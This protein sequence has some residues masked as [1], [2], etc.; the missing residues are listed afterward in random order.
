M[1]KPINN[2]KNQEAEREFIPLPPDGYVCK[3]MGAKVQEYS[4]CTMLVVSIDIAE[5]EFKDYYTNDYRSQ[6]VED[7]KWRGNLR[8][9][10]PNEDNPG[11]YEESTRRKFKSFTNAL[12]DS[13]NFTW[14]WDETKLK[15]LL[16]GLVFRNE[17]WVKD[18]KSGWKA[19]PFKCISVD[20]VRTGNFTVPNDK[21]LKDAPK[22]STA[23]AGFTAIE[24]EDDDLPF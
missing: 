6:T 2:W 7:K 16:L 8:L 5:G 9:Y 4:S 22:S 19:Q 21:P 1:I 3:I 18:D 17:Q 15:G 10:I 12:E 11:K 14:E 20:D 23:P 24:D 13:N